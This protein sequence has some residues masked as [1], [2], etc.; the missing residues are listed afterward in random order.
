MEQLRITALIMTCCTSLIG[1]NFSSAEQG[2]WQQ[3]EGLARQLVR[4][5]PS[6]PRSHL[7]LPRA[8]VGGP[9]SFTLDA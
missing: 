7:L 8:T 1:V 6:H 4:E 9:S 2:L 3:K 5:Q